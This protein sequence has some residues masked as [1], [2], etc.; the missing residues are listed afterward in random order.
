MDQNTSGPGEKKENGYAKH[1]VYTV[2]NPNEDEK[3]GLFLVDYI[4]CIQ[5]QEV[6]DD[7]TPH[8]QGYIV[9][10]TKKR[11]GAM[12]KIMPRAHLEVMRGTSQEASDYCKKEGDYIECGTLPVT[13]AEA[14]GQA[15]KERFARNIAL[16]RSGRMD[17]L[18]E[19]DPASLVQHYHSYKRIVQDYPQK[20]NHLDAVCG[21]WI[22]GA[23]GV[24]KSRKARDDYPDSLYDKPCNKWWDGYRGE[25]TI[26]IDDFDLGHK[27]LGH[28]LKRWADRYSFPAEQKGTTLQIRPKRIVVTSNYSIESIF[29]E[30][31]VLQEA[32]KRRF[33]VTHMVLG[34]GP[35]L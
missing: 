35:A 29:F 4:Y 13:A 2:N 17:E 18:M 25:D 34:I 28:H 14:G 30:D 10:K 16:A 3:T 5:G 15:S 22:W 20:P 32:I 11:L 33:T 12:K 31:D 27:V 24:G 6:G 7:G 23:T 9:M 8:V 19:I 1:W 26:L 21:I